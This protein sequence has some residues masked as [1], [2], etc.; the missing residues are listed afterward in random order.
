MWIVLQTMLIIII[1]QV[2]WKW[3]TRM[4]KMTTIAVD[5]RATLLEHC[6]H[7]TQSCYLSVTN[8]LKINSF[9][10]WAAKGGP[11]TRNIDV[12]ISGYPRL[13]NYFSGSGSERWNGKL[14]HVKNKV[15]GHSNQFHTGLRSVYESHFMRS[16]SYM[17]T[18]CTEW[19]V[20][21][22]LSSQLIGVVM[23]VEPQPLVFAA[24]FPIRLYSYNSFLLHDNIWDTYFSHY[25]PIVYQC[26]M[27]LIWKSLALIG[28]CVRARVLISC[29][30][31]IYSH[32]FVLAAFQSRSMYIFL[33]LESI[34]LT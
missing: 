34:Q 3:H 33:A 4:M 26:G 16:H 8:T 13:P 10:F 7:W 22:P 20:N 18:Y 1:R 29:R 14:F 11:S 23:Y 19:P 12:V 30:C 2:W 21:W 32:S 31:L 28:V 17:Y 6:W 9:P 5:F 15:S 27:A 24:K 25:I